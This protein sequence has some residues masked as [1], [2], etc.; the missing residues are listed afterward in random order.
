MS[1]LGGKFSRSWH[2]FVSSLQ[3]IGRQPKLL[4][5]PAM[6]FASTLVVILCFLAP[7]ALLPTGHTWGQLE[8]WKAVAHRLF[9]LAPSGGSTR[10]AIPTTTAGIYLVVLY[11]ASMFC[12]TFFN[13]ASYHEIIKALAG[14]EVSIGEGL[15]FANRRL[16][17]I[18]IWSL[19]AGAVGLIIM[20]LEKRFG[21]VGRWVMRFVG[22]A[23][24]VASVFVIPVIVREECANPFALLRTSAATLK[25]TWGES[26]I[27]Y[28]G[29]AIGSWIILLG[30]LALLVAVGLMLALLH[31]PVLILA[32]VA[33][34]VLALVAFSYLVSVANRTFRGALY[35]YASEGVVP[36]PYSVELLDAAWKVRK[37]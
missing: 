16:R 27:G 20:A 33:L 19:F 17:A 26:L 7:V 13:V 35:V 36:A 21:W 12:A 9:E 23:W 37:G 8:H 34:W 30:S 11:L 14:D 6:A 18:L 2:L 25:K 24:S 29:I 28:V 32:V 10:Q 3:I 31:H 22:M 1:D 15:R 4:L 5:F